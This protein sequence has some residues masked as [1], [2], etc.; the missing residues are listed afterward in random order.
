[1]GV[2]E[3]GKVMPEIAHDDID[4]EPPL[5]EMASLTREIQ[6]Y[7]AQNGL[8]SSSAPDT[9][10]MRLDPDLELQP[11]FHFTQFSFKTFGLGNFPSS[12]M[13]QFDFPNLITG[14]TRITH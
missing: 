10:M 9:G 11:S 5:V 7:M 14:I 3:K 1:M 2:A 12:S 13:P 8:P 4:P 6:E